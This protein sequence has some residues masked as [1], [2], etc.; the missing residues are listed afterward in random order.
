MLLGLL[1]VATY[2]H[3]LAEREE[4]QEGSVLS[5]V[6]VR[7]IAEDEVSEFPQLTSLA[8]QPDQPVSEPT[9]P[10]LQEASHEFAEP[11]A[12]GLGFQHASLSAFEA[13][14]HIQN[15]DRRSNRRM[16]RVGQ[17]AGGQGPARSLSRGVHPRIAAAGRYS[18]SME[19]ADRER[20][21]RS[22]LE[23]LSPYAFNVIDYDEGR[24]SN[25]KKIQFD[26]KDEADLTR[27]LAHPPL[28]NTSRPQARYELIPLGIDGSIMLKVEGGEIVD[29]PGDDFLIYSPGTYGALTAQVQVA[30]KSD[31]FEETRTEWTPIGGRVGQTTSEH[32]YDLAQITAK[33]A[34]RIWI[35][36]E[37]RKMAPTEEVNVGFAMDGEP[38]T[39]PDNESREYAGA[40]LDSVSLV[41][42]VKINPRPEEEGDE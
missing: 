1:S 39:V 5:P 3:T 27:R 29:G 24:D 8:R 7:S 35:K 23:K 14:R 9:S 31:D 41:H 36:D 37:T 22:G 34:N 38:S 13:Q 40:D 26:Y 12:S 25:G 42:A 10:Q 16:S 20:Q 28:G 11:L 32:R 21:L 30:N 2:R 6:T 33:K 4:V 18:P 19:E 17:V 15:A